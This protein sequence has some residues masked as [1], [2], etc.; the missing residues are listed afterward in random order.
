ME[1]M[2][3]EIKTRYLAHV[4]QDTTGSWLVHDLDEH[5]QCVG[6]LASSMAKDFESEEWA[7]A[8]GLWHD[9]GK[10]RKAFQSY[11]AK[12][13]GYNPDAHIEQGQ[14]RVDHSTSGAIHAIENNKAIGQLMAY[15]IA[16]H[17]A[18][19]P[20]WEMSD[21]GNSALS[22][23]LDKGK[24]LGYRDEALRAN[25]PQA[26]LWPEIKL[27][28]PLGGSDGL[29]LWLRMLFSCLVD[30][31]F[32]D[33]EQFMSPERAQ[34]RNTCYSLATLKE[35]FDTYME[36]K[37]KSSADT[38]VNRV[39]ASILRDCRTAALEAPG[40]FT[41]TV[42]TGGGKTLSGMAFALE[43]A[44][45][46]EKKRIIVAIPYTSIIEQT[47]EEYRK[48]FGDS[49]LEHH[50][51]LDPEC[52]S[53][54][55]R[56]ASENWD[57][58]IIVTTNVQLLES[59]FAAKTSRCRKLHNI[60]NSVI[61][62][63]EAQLLPPDFL[64]PVLH[65][66]R[67][68][69]EHYGVTLVLSTATQP[70][71]GSVKDTFGKTTLCGLD[72]KKEIISDVDFLFRSLN[73]IDVT[74]PADLNVRTCWEDLAAELCDHPSVLVV[75]NSRKNARELFRLMPPGTI[76]LSAQM[77]GEHRSKIIAS[78]KRRLQE[79][80]TVRVISTQLVEAGVD[81]D[82]PV[83]YRALAGL[84]S[85]AQA[86]G[87]CN[88]EGKL[89]KGKVVVFVP[90]KSP[91]KGMLL[92]GEQATRTVWHGGEG[93]ALSYSLFERY[94][95][96]Y[97]GQ[98]VP[99][100]HG[101]MALLTKD[102]RQGVVQFRS[103]AQRFHLIADVGQSVLVPYGEDGFKW[104][105]LLRH[106]GPERYLMRK[107]QRYSVNVYENE[108]RKLQ[109][110]GAIEELHPGIWG[111]RIT[112]GYDENLGLLLADDLYSNKPEHSVF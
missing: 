20:D 47:A 44:V 27:G 39:R 76:H 10:Y 25:I 24:K 30:A 50:S 79:N 41:L 75:V 65:V 87:R 9:L 91:P 53:S 72:A 105:D 80:D 73:R 21:A 35:R 18:G 81:L 103:A 74:V 40:V 70:A 5:L 46:F 112:N 19:L 17:H 110:I 104:L 28:K 49:V 71:L 13:S 100:K 52:E 61:V 108:F 3:S 54:K 96:H 55:S 82:F 38:H 99:D 57:A 111:L 92:F 8:A 88:R 16:G 67:L 97:F 14:D 12:E 90:P 29:H 77:C 109:E 68:L 42:P 31:D 37:V 58:P 48:I 101:I 64:Q 45:K 66:L 63:D 4:K 33:T 2:D 7:K 23:R 83:V 85:I 34:D 106:Q 102:A 60:V 78:I 62:I 98:E 59:L 36:E 11:I 95:R 43:H 89:E 6:R 22:S 56:L 15:L 86:A 84:D 94:F 26:V 93:D 51:N 107:L 32:L 69:T 1:L